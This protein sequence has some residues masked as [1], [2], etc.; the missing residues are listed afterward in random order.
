MSEAQARG[1]LDH[2]LDPGE[3]VSLHVIVEVDVEETLGPA[4]YGIVAQLWQLG[5]RS[6]EAVLQL[7]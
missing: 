2:C 1:T 6:D 7:V 5:L 4:H 3:S